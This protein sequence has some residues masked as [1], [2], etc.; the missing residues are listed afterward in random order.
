MTRSILAGLLGL[1]S[2]GAVG[3]LPLACQSGGIGDPCTPED[4]YSSAFA[5]FKMT[6]EN[7]E[8]RSFQCST[9]I[10]L[11]NHFQGRTTCPQ[12]QEPPKSCTRDANHLK[13]PHDKGTC[14]PATKDECVEAAVDAEDCIPQ[15]ATCKTSEE[16][17]GGGSCVGGK[18][19][20]PCRAGLSCDKAR[21][22]CACT[23]QTQ[24]PEG[25]ACYHSDPNDDQSV[26]VL[27]SFVC[28]TP[29]NCQTAGADAKTNTG[30]DCCVP[31]TDTP[32]TSAVCGQCLG[33]VDK[34]TGAVTKKS[35]RSADQSVYCSCRCGVADGADPEPNFNFCEC[36]TGFS[37]SQ[38]RPNV[39]LG[40]IQITGK[41]CVKEDTEYTGAPVGE[42][43]TVTG[44]LDKTCMS[45]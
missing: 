31:G 25:Y 40:D 27:K 33:T 12:G 36:P 14:D 19:P 2:I 18:C 38:V 45:N 8:S 24:P 9:R 41:Y 39:G 42:C 37:C 11:V 17:V 30:K 3:A 6:E 1:F 23:D 13:D 43:G 28:H 7:I 32:T 21:K 44:Y 26:K 10:C 35:T 22:V 20:N 4:E 5:G 16:C 34:K 15:P 29:G